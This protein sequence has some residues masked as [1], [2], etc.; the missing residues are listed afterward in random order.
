MNG[1]MHALQKLI[2]LKKTK[3]IL[4]GLWIMGLTKN[5]KNI[6]EWVLRKNKE[7]NRTEINEYIS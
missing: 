3:R 4:E 2:G 7:M 1:W 6:L 5:A